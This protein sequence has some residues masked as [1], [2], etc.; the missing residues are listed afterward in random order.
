[1]GYKLSHLQKPFRNAVKHNILR[2]C[3]KIVAILAVLYHGSDL[4]PS[5]RHKYCPTG[6]ETW[7]MY[8]VSPEAFVHKSY[9]LDK[10]IFEEI[11]QYL[12]ITQV[13]Q[14]SKSYCQVT[15]APFS[16][17]SCVLHPV[18]TVRESRYTLTN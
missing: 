6:S 13:I 17:L 11:S 18:D 15:I 2:N 8:Q 5:E 4:D 14:F 1:M 9:H 10:A 3:K 12:S 7:C 16:V